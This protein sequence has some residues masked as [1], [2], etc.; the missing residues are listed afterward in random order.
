MDPP[1]Y[2]GSVHPDEWINSIQKY[3]SFWKDK[4]INNSEYISYVKSLVD[5]TIKLPAEIGNYE[6]LNN[7]LKEFLYSI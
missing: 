6:K 3:I 5:I 7:A 2:D 1:K 4:S